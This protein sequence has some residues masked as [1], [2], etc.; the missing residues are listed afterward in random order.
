MFWGIGNTAPLA[1]GI[2]SPDMSVG[3]LIAQILFLV[4]F[5]LFL[6]SFKRKFFKIVCACAIE[7]TLWL[8][9]KNLFGPEAIIT[10]IF[11]WF[12]AA[13]AII[14]MIAIVNRINWSALRRGE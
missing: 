14:L 9:L 5:T 2:I 3:H 11:T 10:Q 12:T 13:A 7:V 4:A 8:M 1:A 6:F